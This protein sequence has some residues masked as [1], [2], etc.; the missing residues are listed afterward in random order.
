MFGDQFVSDLAF[1][2]NN[3]FG[4]AV[5]VGTGLD[6]LED[7]GKHPSE[8]HPSHYIPKLSDLLPF[9]NQKK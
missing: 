6:S 2:R 3:K 7:I 1:A 9:L 8:I 4:G 5:L